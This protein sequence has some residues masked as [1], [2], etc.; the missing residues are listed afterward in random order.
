M[1]RFVAMPSLN[2]ADHFFQLGFPDS[3]LV[4][5]QIGSP[6]LLAKFFFYLT[7]KHLK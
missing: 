3:V 1:T 4:C 7:G 2:F 6:V 5:M